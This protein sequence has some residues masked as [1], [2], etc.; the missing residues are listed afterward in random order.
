MAFIG[1][2]IQVV[3]AIALVIVL[4][5]IAF[6]VFNAEMLRAIKE[7]GTVRRQVQVFT[8]VKDL[9][10]ANNEAYNT[11]DPTNPMYRNIES[12]VNQKSGAEYTYNF[13]LFLNPEKSPVSDSPTFSDRKENIPDVGF[14]QYNS[15]VQL[16]NKPFVLLLRGDKKVVPYK[17]ICSSSNSANSDRLKMDVLVKQPMIKLEHGW[18]ALTVELNTQDRPDAVKEKSRNTC[19]SSETD[20]NT[21]NS[22]R[23][24]VENV[25][26]KLSGKWNMITVVIQ[27]T[28]PTDPLPIRNKVRVRVYVNGMLEIDRY[29]DGK[30]ADTSSKATLL[31]P[32]SGDL[33]VAPKIVMNDSAGTYLS[34]TLTS[35]QTNAVMMADLSYFNYAIDTTQIKSLFD[36]GFSKQYAPSMT[37]NPAAASAL[38]GEKADTTADR[39]LRQL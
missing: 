30:L 17:S 35:S 25:K 8:G 21:L 14:T 15:K 31:R 29:L 6:L 20:W 22:Y 34:S 9:A 33:H 5:V 12:S 18:D 39:I 3:I 28:F 19:N 10:V 13:W 24:G 38:T 23:V 32:N 1:S 11:I 16:Q 2:T 37:I 26:Q 27:D 4:C 7:A 36:A